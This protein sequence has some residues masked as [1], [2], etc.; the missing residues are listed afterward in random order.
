MIHAALKLETKGFVNLVFVPSTLRARFINLWYKS[1][2]LSVSL[3]PTILPVV[4]SLRHISTWCIV[5]IRDLF[6]SQVK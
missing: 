1:I 2:C 6:G 5:S 3:K 4:E